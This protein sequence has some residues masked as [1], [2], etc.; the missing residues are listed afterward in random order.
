M[1]ERTPE[2]DL[3]DIFRLVAN[4]T[5]VGIIRA[6]WAAHTEDP[7]AIDGP[8]S[9]PVSFS[10]LRDRVGVGDSGRFNYHLDE[11][12]PQFVEKR[13]GGYV[14]T[15]AGARIVGAAVSGV[16]T[17]SDVALEEPTMGT[18]TAA[19]CGGTLE[20]EYERGHVTVACDACSWETVLYAPPIVAETHDEGTQPD[21]LQRYTTS[22]VQRMA[23]GFCTLC[24]GPVR[25]RVSRSVAA[26]DTPESG[27]VTVVHQ[28]GECGNVAHTTATVC[29]LDHP[30]VVS[31]L[32]DA[33]FDYRRLPLWR[34]PRAIDR[35]E[36]LQGVDPV[37]VTVRLA[38]G[39]DSL[40]VLLDDSLDVV[41]Y[42]RQAASGTST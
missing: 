2:R 5:R 39:G 30:A 22:E 4:D 11:L 40:R 32:H 7:D 20:A 42:S 14:L 12:V 28:C 24:S 25:A 13:E 19:D 35:E 26:A 34:V 3:E 17:G 9:D 29:L 15:D 36:T 21:A 41:E 27:P 37:R 33:G 1:S 10:S 38:A 16:Y 23:R 8:W 6:L 31:L 18:C